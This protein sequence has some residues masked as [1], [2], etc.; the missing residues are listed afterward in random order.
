MSL[1]F[2]ASISVRRGSISRRMIWGG[3]LSSEAGYS[4]RRDDAGQ[5]VYDFR[6][7]RPWAFNWVNYFH[8]PS[9]YELSLRARH[10]QQQGMSRQAAHV[11]AYREMVKG[12]GGIPED[13]QHAEPR[14]S[15]A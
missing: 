2:S 13:G 3:W 14:R 7:E 6:L 5:H 4:K 11:R 8:M 12:A 1:A 9:N 10:F 15:R